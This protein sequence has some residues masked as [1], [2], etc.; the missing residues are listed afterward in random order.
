M[1]E[2]KTTPILSVRDIEEY[3]FC[4]R[5][6][7]YRVFLSRESFQK[8]WK[9]AGRKFEA[10]QILIIK[11]KF[12]DEFTFIEPQVYESRKYRIRGKPDFILK[13]KKFKYYVV[14]DVKNSNRVKNEFVTTLAVYALLLEDCGVTPVKRALL[15]LQRRIE[16]INITDSLREKAKYYIKAAHKVVKSGKIPKGNWKNCRL[17]DFR[18]YCHEKS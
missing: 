18:E 7:Y 3:I 9:E 16:W 12:T 13:H 8:F 10:E 6:F 17:C 14:G 2:L 11:N 15:V 5:L 1:F 4:P